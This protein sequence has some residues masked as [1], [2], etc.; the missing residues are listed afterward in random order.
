MFESLGDRLQ[1]V[2]KELRGEGHLTDYHLESA[3]RQIRLS[4]LEADV[5]LPVVRDFTARVKERAVGA[6]VTQQ[7]SPAQEVTKIVRDELI[8]LLG[9]A[10]S[11]IAFQGTPAVILLAGLQ[12][13]GKTTSAAKLARH[14][15]TRGRYPLVVAAD[16]TRPAAVQQLVILGKQI[17]IPVFEP[18]SLKNPVEVA[19]E[20][21]REAK[22][23]GRDTV[24]VDTA[25][26]L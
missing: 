6:K 25:G 8:A 15:K 23:T 1:G 3:L 26:R 22:Q 7:L 16:L 2:F 14:L 18:G 5:A 13:S 11:D 10:T 19:R 17:G 9:G 24:I 20:G 12:G 4:L 21:V